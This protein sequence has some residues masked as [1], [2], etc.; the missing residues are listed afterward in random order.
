MKGIIKFKKGTPNKAG[1]YITLTKKGKVEIRPFIGSKWI[2]DNP[3]S[4][5]SLEDII[6]LNNILD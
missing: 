3:I 4:W 6:L 2:P 1:Q 5:C